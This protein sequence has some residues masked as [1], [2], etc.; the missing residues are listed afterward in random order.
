M[1][2]RNFT[3]IELLVVIA[4]IAILAAMLMPALNKARE[5]ARK[6]SCMNQLKQFAGAGIF[7]QDDN[8]GYAGP[9]RPYSVYH[10]NYYLHSKRDSDP[11]Q[12][13]VWNAALFCPSNNKAGWDKFVANGGFID[14]ARTSYTLN[15]FLRYPTSAANTNT[16]PKIDKVRNPSSKIYSTEIAKVG[17]DLHSKD[18]IVYNATNFLP[19]S[20]S[21]HGNGSNF[22]YCD[23]HVDFKSDSSPEREVKASPTEECKAV[24]QWWY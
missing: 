6:T 14:C 10:L 22:S 23:G 1:K 18:G 8:D 2:V 20:Y 17:Y 16:P 4:I 24:W 7:Y 12:F 5:S 11:A 13:R 3:L 21:K 19:Y 15:D 9:P